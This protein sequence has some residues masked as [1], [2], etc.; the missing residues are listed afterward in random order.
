MREKIRGTA[1]RPRLSVFRSLTAIYV[2]AIDDVAGHTLAVAS[3]RASDIGDVAGSPTDKSKAAGE[4]LAERLKAA[5]IERAVFDRNTYR[6]H[7]RVRAL[8]D[9]VRA[10]GIKF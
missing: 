2:Q 6:Y 7:G 8:A 1:E 9:G 4:L 10:G 3:S 5:G